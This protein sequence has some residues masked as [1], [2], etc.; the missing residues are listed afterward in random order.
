MGE[1]RREGGSG[2][3]GPWSINGQ[4]GP[5]R[6]GRGGGGHKSAVDDPEGQH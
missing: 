1:D 4:F 6:G 5:E 3:N 2:V